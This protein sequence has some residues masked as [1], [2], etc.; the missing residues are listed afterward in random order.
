MNRL[1]NLVGGACAIV[2]LAG[3]ACAQ[4]A[5]AA[6]RRGE[7]DQ[8]EARGIADPIT[9][10]G[11]LRSGG[12]PANGNFPMTFR[13]FDVEVGGSPVV[14]A[15]YASIPVSDG[16]FTVQLS[17]YNSMDGS[18]R[19]IEVEV[20]GNVL[21]PRQQVT[22]TPY[23]FK[24]RSLQWPA[25]ETMDGLFLSLTST[26]SNAAYFAHTD[27]IGGAVN[28]AFVG[29]SF[30]AVDAYS[31]DEVGVLA[32]TDTGIGV[33]ASRFADNGTDPAV[34]ATSDS[35]SP[36]AN[37]IVGELTT[38]SPGTGS[39]GVR[40]INNG[41]GKEGY[42]V[43]GSHAGVGDG[44]HG[45]SLLGNGVSAMTAGG[46]A[47]FAQNTSG[48]GSLFLG[49]QPGTFCNLGGA[50]IVTV[51][52]PQPIT[53][54]PGLYI[55]E[56]QSTEFYSSAVYAKQSAPG[57]NDSPAIVG[58]ND[59]VDGEGIGITGVGGWHGV[60]GLCTGAGAGPYIGL[61]GEAFTA[62]GTARGVYGFAQGSGALH[63]G[64]FYGNV[65]VVGALS[66]GAGSFKIDHPLD[67]YNK[68]LYHSFV[69]SPDMK[70]IYDGTVVLN[71][72]G[73]ARVEM[74]DYFEALNMQFRYQLTPI[75]A[76]MPNL[77]VAQ[78]IQNGVFMIAGGVPGAEVSWQ[79]TGVR[80]D[81]YA[82]EHRIPVEEW[83]QGREVGKL[84]HPTAFGRSEAEGIDG[85][86]RAEVEARR[87]R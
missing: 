77:Y 16:V 86:E 28:R 70:N 9:Y 39:T 35:M 11:H 49:S 64:Y 46:N 55:E 58:V 51:G 61:Y 57:G 69:E 5:D 31:E 36:S 53:S 45:T 50:Q 24:S 76:S 73:M 48:D 33:R 34:Y 82:N 75:G 2:G 32:Q 23:A 18:D 80:Q 56:S 84:L 12:Q 13:I 85:S 30:G 3:M 20:N 71:G 41:T 68:F 54:K 67:P 65:H 74:P 66:K 63:A 79:V 14:T 47:M 25:V 52:G 4:Q 22:A 78:K 62:G 26:S 43:W 8:A 60:D 81:A 15:Q 21:S 7:P 72:Q 59:D 1:T 6:A 29:G 38:S 44:V 27:G 87:N 17:V 40:G 19:W 42:G 37:A 10:Q 83:K